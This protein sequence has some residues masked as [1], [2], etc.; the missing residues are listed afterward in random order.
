[1]QW[2]T[3]VLAAVL[4]CG[5][6]AAGELAP[7]EIVRRC[8]DLLRG[9]ESYC[10]LTMAVV[11]PKWSRTVAMEAWTRGTED[12]FIRVLSPP[13]EKGVTFLKKGREAWQYA[14]SIDRVVKIPPSM[15]LQ[16]WLGSDFTNDDMV[17]ADSIVVDYDHAIGSEPEEDGV[18]Y[19][20]VEARPKPSAP[21]VWGRVDLKIRKEDFIPVRVDYYDEDGE[22]VKYYE[23]AGFAEVE[24]RRLATRMTMHDQTRPG[25]RTEVR[26]ESLTFR[27]DLR[28][29]TFTVQNLRQ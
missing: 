23:T 13:K 24:G 6:A 27:P 17:R 16:S 22:R 28:P 14:P 9:E 19:W 1:M 11:R 25:H 15:M 8:D 12:S 26:Y 21:V 4:A 5:P 18:A 2:A 20:V 7:V 29:D 10:K 3:G